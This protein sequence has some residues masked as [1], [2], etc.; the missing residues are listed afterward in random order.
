MAMFV[1]FAFMNCSD[2][3]ALRQAC[4]AQVPLL[5]VLVAAAVHDLA[6]SAMNLYNNRPF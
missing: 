3:Q 4:A 2:S 6:S 5:D 1:V